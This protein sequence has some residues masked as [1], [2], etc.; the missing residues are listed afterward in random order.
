[1]STFRLPGSGR[2]GLGLFCEAAMVVFA[3]LVELA[4]KDVNGQRRNRNAGLMNSPKW[5]TASNVW[6]RAYPGQVLVREGRNAMLRL[7]KR[8]AEG[9]G[10][11][12]NPS[13]GESLGLLI[14]P[15]RHEQW[16]NYLFQPLNST[17]C[18]RKFL[19]YG[20]NISSREH[21]KSPRWRPRMSVPK[22]L[23]G[24]HRSRNP[25]LPWR[26]ITVNRIPPRRQSHAHHRVNA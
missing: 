15:R 20:A 26:P 1:M 11:R 10:W 21:E 6:T 16:L 12:G 3:L 4:Q 19:A 23:H 2:I 25:M 17:S 9:H 14:R 8:V 22:S 7:R 18:C 13:W 5:G 24:I